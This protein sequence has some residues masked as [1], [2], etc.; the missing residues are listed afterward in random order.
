MFQSVI[1]TLGSWLHGDLTRITVQYRI[2]YCT[3]LVLSIAAASAASRVL[4]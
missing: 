3:C 1:A 2:T 4:C